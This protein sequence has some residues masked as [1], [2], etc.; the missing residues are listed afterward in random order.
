MRM[1]WERAIGRCR[2]VVLVLLAAL[3]ILIGHA[4]GPVR[5]VLRN[6]A[7]AMLRPL[8]SCARLLAVVLLH[9][10]M[11]S[12]LDAS[13][14]TAG[15]RSGSRSG[16]RS[17][18]SRGFALFSAGERLAMLRPRRREGS[19]SV[20]VRSRASCRSSEADAL[21]RRVAALRKALG[22]LPGLARRLARALG[23][24]GGAAVPRGAVLAEAGRWLA[25]LAAPVVARAVVP[26]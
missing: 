11:R 12:L 18:G 3:P 1:D 22:D 7:L 4:P 2:G 23:R 25:G 13:S 6:G 19:R 15:R 14:R 21:A 16:G 5:R 26:P 24:R 20:G 8:E 9:T 10:S 17:G